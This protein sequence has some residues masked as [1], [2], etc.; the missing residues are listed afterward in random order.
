MKRVLLTVAVALLIP[1]I[2][3]AAPVTVGVYYEGGLTV[4]PPDGPYYE[5]KVALYMVQSEYNIT[6]IEYV[7]GGFDNA[8]PVNNPIDLMT[9]P[10]RWY[11]LSKLLPPN[12]QA[13]LGDPIEGHSITYWPPLN[14]FPTGYDLLCSYEFYTTTPCENITNYRIEVLPHPDTGYLRATYAPDNEKIELLGLSLWFCP[15]GVGTEEQSWGAI[16]A[17][18]R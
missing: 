10:I 11:N 17:Q 18:Y 1:S 7:L 5:F 12:A 16:K 2:L 8:Q 3:M 4:V 14:G 9:G 13:E 6:G 15:E